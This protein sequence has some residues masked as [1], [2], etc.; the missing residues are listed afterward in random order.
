[1]IDYL[2]ILAA[3]QSD[4]GTPQ[5]FTLGQLIGGTLT[6]PAEDPFAMTAPGAEIRRLTLLD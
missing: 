2:R 5:V 6:E 4:E 1:L 3:G